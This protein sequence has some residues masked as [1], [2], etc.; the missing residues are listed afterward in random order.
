MGFYD[1]ARGVLASLPPSDG[2]PHALVT[3]YRSYLTAAD[4][5][6][7][8]A[9][10]GAL[11]ERGFD[12]CGAFATSLKAPDVADWLRVHFTECTPAAIVNATAFSAMGDDGTTPFDAAS[13]PVFQVALST[14]RKEDWASSLRGLSPADLATDGCS[15]VWSASSR[16][17]SAM[18]ICSSPIWRIS[19]IPS[20]SMRPSTGF[21]R[22]SGWR[23]CPRAR[24]A[25]P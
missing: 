9:L 10:I 1:P 4:T 16:R 23:R 3:F 22:G 12:A 13:C 24:S 2:L 17:A 21:V 15:P 7:V 11:R 8:D 18:P 5:G 25:L 20:A 14:A 19:Q 6:P